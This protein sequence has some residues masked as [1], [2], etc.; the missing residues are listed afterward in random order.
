MLQLF[1]TLIYLK[2]IQLRYQVWYRLKRFLPSKKYS[3]N[4]NEAASLRWKE[5]IKSYSTYNQCTFN[6]LNLSKTFNQEIDWNFHKYGKLWVYNLTYFDFLHQKEMDTSEGVRLMLS[7][8]K[9]YASCKDGKEPYPTSL[10]IINWVKYLSENKIDNHELK[11]VLRKDLTRLSDNLEYHLLANHLLENALALLF[12]AYYFKDEKVYEKA[13]SLL[14]EQLEEQIMKDGAHYEQSPMY[15]QIILYKVLDCIQLVAKNQWKEERGLKLLLSDKAA[16]MTNWLQQITFENGDIPLFNDAAKSIA[17]TTEQLVNYAKQLNI[18]SKVL[19]LGESGYRAFRSE[20]FEMIAD[21][22][23]LSPSYQ[24]GHSHADALQF[25]L[26]IGGKPCI[27]DSGTATYE[28]NERRAYERSTAAHNTVTVAN[29]NSSDVW[30]SFRVGRRAKVSILKDDS[31]YLEASHSGY[32]HLGVTHKRAFEITESSIKINDHLEG[33]IKNG[34]AHLHFHPAVGVKQSSADSFFIGEAKLNI[35]GASKILV[36][37]YQWSQQ[38]NK[39]EDATVLKI[40]F[41][42]LVSTS[43]NIK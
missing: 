36:E 4:Y 5:W 9:K 8:A 12:G 39:T 25:V 30:S 21:V 24:P 37:S 7:F 27:V 29:K 35:A 20:Q 14:T 42:G 15:H 10:R 22:G 26:N 1:Q 16:K 2:L 40:Y 11:I 34:I 17:P 32:L 23:N 38:F 3:G 41:E 19:P 31:S 18:E 28:N 13:T 6:F 33:R 43:I